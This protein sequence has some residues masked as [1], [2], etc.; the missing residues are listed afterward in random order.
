MVSSTVYGQ[1]PFLN[2]IYGVLCGY[3]YDV[4]M[5]HMGTVPTDPRLSAFESCLAAVER[6]DA[7]LGI[8]TG[9]Y[10]SGVAKGERSITHQE[11]ARAVELGKPRWF[12]VHHDVVVARQLLRQFR[13]G[14]DGRPKRLRFQRT[15]ILDD[16][17][18]LEMYEAAIQQDRPLLAR[19]GNWAQEFFSPENAPRFVDAQ[20]RDQ[21]RVRGCSTDQG[22]ET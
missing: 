14:R 4:W 22:G 13:F 2:Q 17:R 6:C 3:G 21:E 5:S 11:I 10:G 18:V 19:V 12:L 8:I 20:F 16:I 15:A 1:E 7:F 9:R